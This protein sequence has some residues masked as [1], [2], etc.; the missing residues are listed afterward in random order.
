MV[1]GVGIMR[2]PLTGIEVQDIAH[3][4][5]NAAPGLVAVFL[6]QQNLL[7]TGSNAVRMRGQAP[8]LLA[9]GVHFSDVFSHGQ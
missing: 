3:G 2:M 4:K 9:D 7:I 6:T 5:A 8:T 1:S